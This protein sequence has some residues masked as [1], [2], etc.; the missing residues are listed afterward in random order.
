MDNKSFSLHFNPL[1]NVKCVKDYEEEIAN[2]KAE[3]FELKAQITH[4][5]IPKVLYEN[6]QEQLLYHP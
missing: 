3:N 6:N 4:T 2:L 5:N 1:T